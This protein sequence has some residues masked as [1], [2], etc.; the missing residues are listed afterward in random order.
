MVTIWSNHPSN[1]KRGCVCIF[2][3]ETLGVRVVS[4]SNVCYSECIICEVSIQNNESYIGVVCR[5]RSQDANE[6]QKFLSNFKI[7]VS[8]T[9]A[10]NAL[11]IIILG[12]CNAGSSP[13]ELM[14]KPEVDLRLL[15]HTRWS[16]F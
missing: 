6:F 12:D 5:S 15:Q 3:K 7:N 14:T 11:F 4:L 9:T 2:Y 8:N 16:A 13:D 1:V 10:N